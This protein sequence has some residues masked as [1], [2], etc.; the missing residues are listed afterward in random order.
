MRGKGRNWAARQAQ[1]LQF[2]RDYIAANSIA[3]TQAEINIATGI[4][5]RSSVKHRLDALQ[6]DGLIRWTPTIPRSIVLVDTEPPIDNVQAAVT[7]R[8]ALNASLSMAR[9]L[10]DERRYAAAKRDIA[11]LEN[12]LRWL[13]KQQALAAT[14]ATGVRVDW[15]V[16]VHEGQRWPRQVTA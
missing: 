3:P 9:Y 5:S 12:A 6:A 4:H 15:P 10:S 14:A 16:V 8:R 13:D 11:Q 7:I 1:L 2:I